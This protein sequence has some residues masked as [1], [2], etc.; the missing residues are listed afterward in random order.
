MGTWEWH[1]PGWPHDANTSSNHKPLEFRIKIYQLPVKWIDLRTSDSMEIEN[2]SKIAFLDMLFYR[3]TDGCFTTSVYRKTTHTDQSVKLG[4]VK[5]VCAT[6]QNISW[7]NI[8]HST[9]WPSW[10]KWCCVISWHH[11]RRRLAV[12]SRNVAIYMSSQVTMINVF[13]N[14]K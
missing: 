7:L 11:P 13:I 3:E 4:N 9:G 2:N 14:L 5:C 10:Y 1:R 12:S 6:G 8:S